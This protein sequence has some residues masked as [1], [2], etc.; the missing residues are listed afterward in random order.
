VRS[1][2]RADR[3]P[4]AGACSSF[5]GVASAVGKGERLPFGG[6]GVGGGTVGLGAATDV[7]VAEPAATAATR[8][9]ATRRR[10]PMGLTRT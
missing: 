5:A 3:A 7:R 9:A 1:A 4:I 8:S 6:T 10:R 2:S